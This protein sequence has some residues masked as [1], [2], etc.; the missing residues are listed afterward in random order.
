VLYFFEIFV[1]LLCF[2]DLTQGKAAV[3]EKNLRVEKNDAILEDEAK[4]NG[5][6]YVFFLILSHM[7]MIYHLRF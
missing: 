2:P 6:M 4:I 3:N 1:E 5:E 7:I